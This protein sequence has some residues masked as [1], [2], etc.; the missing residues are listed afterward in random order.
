[1]LVK[2]DPFTKQFI[3]FTITTVMK[4]NYAREQRN[5]NI[6]QSSIAE[7]F[8]TK[9]LILFLKLNDCFSY[10]FMQIFLVSQW[11]SERF[12]DLAFIGEDL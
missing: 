7:L 11:F 12:S 1:M 2:K 3:N 9:S 6:N 5:K 4:R 10:I 8:F